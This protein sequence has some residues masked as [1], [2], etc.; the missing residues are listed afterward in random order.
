[1]RRQVPAKAEA[2]GMNPEIL[3]AWEVETEAQRG[4]HTPVCAQ[5]RSEVTLRQLSGASGLSHLI[6]E[7]AYDSLT[8]RTEGKAW[9][10]EQA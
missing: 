2:L 8:S 1:M 4:G 6:S 10:E 3:T 7:P 9:G 5:T